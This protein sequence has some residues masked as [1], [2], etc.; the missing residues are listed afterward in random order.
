MSTN[1]FEIDIA[2][3]MKA[4]EIQPVKPDP[5]T[6]PFLHDTME[7]P[8]LPR[9]EDTEPF[10]RAIVAAPED[11]LPRLMF[12]D[13]LEEHGFD[14]EA[15]Y[16][17]RVSK[18][19]PMR[20]YDDL[21]SATRICPCGQSIS[22][23]TDHEWEEWTKA[24]EPHCNGLVIATPTDDGMRCCTFYREVFRLWKY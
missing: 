6:I 19:P 1:T 23:G 13:W 7:P 3:R 15:A 21:D 5:R 16:H 10:L 17:R 2:L 4:L 14:K 11:A 24:H 8:K 18:N 9:D 22:G 12:A 20:Q